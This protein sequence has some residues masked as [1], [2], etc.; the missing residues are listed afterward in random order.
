MILGP[1]R[2]IALYAKHEPAGS[3]IV[4]ARSMVFYFQDATATKPSG[5]YFAGVTTTVSVV[6]P[7]S[8][9]LQEVLVEVFMSDLTESTI[10]A[11]AIP[12]MKEM[13]NI[14]IYMRNTSWPWRLT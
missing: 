8:L 12:C 3:A 5:M 9:E 7:P 1:K 13:I 14:W 4:V 2:A 10:E 6:P 11:A